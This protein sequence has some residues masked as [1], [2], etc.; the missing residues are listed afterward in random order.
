MAR[1]APVPSPVRLWRKRLL[2]K[3]ATVHTV[4]GEVLTGADVLIEN[5]KIVTVGQVTAQPI[6]SLI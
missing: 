1:P 2:L 6:R 3:N 5:G 4:S